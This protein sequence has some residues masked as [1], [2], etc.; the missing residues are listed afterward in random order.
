MGLAVGEIYEGKVTGITKFG[1]F[2]SF[3]GGQT[4]MVHI[5]EVAPT[6]VNEIKDFVTEGQTVK[7]KVLA[8]SEE[9]KISLSMKKALPPEEQHRPRRQGGGPGQGAGR[10]PDRRPPRAPRPEP[11]PGPGRPGDFEWQGRRNDSGSFED[12]MSRFK[13]TSDEKM[14]DLKRGNET[15][16]GYSRRGSKG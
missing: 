7:V 4:G 13:Q 15:R 1:A 16:R 5:S 10:R 14:S 2:V 3:E 12:M 9:G 6:F 8:I 11:D